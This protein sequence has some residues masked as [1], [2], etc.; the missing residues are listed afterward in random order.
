M[1]TSVTDQQPS[2]QAPILV[3]EDDPTLRRIIQETL[4]DE[5]FAV[6]AAGDGHQA[7]RMAR[8]R[9][10]GL[11]VLDMA[12][13]KLNGLGVAAELRQ[14]Y[15]TAPPILLVTADGRAGHKAQQVGAFAF[16][17]KPLD[18]DEFLTIVR[19]GLEAA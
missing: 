16:L 5:G 7:V 13:P 19:R 11:V 9:R 14:A 12:L 18:L 6:V 10:P 4:E 17:P 3:V 15:K 2:A 8:E 1:H